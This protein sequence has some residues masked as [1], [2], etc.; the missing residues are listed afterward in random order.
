MKVISIIL[1]TMHGSCAEEKKSIE[2]LVPV[3]SDL[4]KI[5]NEAMVILGIL[6]AML[7]EAFRDLSVY[8]SYQGAISLSRSLVTLA[9]ALFMIKSASSPVLVANICFGLT[10]FA[11]RSKAL[12]ESSLSMLPSSHQRGH[13]YDL[14][15]K[16]RP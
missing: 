11:T 5:N 2:V 13:N 12:C 9:L 8:E 4:V 7:T 10:R 14:R 6:V 3:M 16:E 15:H 1:N